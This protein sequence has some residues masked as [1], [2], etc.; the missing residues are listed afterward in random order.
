MNV[1][2][3][4]LIFRCENGHEFVPAVKDGAIVSP[5]QLC[6]R[7]F[8]RNGTAGVC[9]SYVQTQEVRVS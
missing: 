6:T 1:Q 8:V 4:E 2:N 7:P 9:G 3:Y 5:P